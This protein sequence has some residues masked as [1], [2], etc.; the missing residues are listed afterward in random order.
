MLPLKNGTFTCARFH[1][2]PS[3]SPLRKFG[4]IFIFD[5]VARARAFFAM[6]IFVV[7]VHF[8]ALPF[9]RWVRAAESG[10]TSPKKHVVPFFGRRPSN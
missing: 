1:F 6:F 4:F 10:Q 5:D 9:K 2:L 8:D 3:N 7:G